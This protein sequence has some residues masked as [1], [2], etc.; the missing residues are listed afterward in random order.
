[1]FR[2]ETTYVYDISMMDKYSFGLIKP[3]T[4]GAS[5]IFTAILI[6]VL[7]FLKKTNG[8]LKENYQ[9]ILGSI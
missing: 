1:M 5:K 8:V 4:T 7:V 6:T 9:D 3:K 2:I